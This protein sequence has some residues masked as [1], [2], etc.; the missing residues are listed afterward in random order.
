M[1]ALIASI[2][3]FLAFIYRACSPHVN[4]K[5]E[6]WWRFSFCKRFWTNPL[7]FPCLPPAGPQSTD[8]L[9]ICSFCTNCFAAFFMAR[10]LEVYSLSAS[11]GQSSCQLS[12]TR[13]IFYRKTLPTIFAGTVYGSWI[14]VLVSH[15]SKTSICTGAM[16][17]ECRSA[18]RLFCP[19][20]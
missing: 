18:N 11:H 19:L 6:L 8:T 9:D 3:H 13:K 7:F 4:V 12:K 1:E 2:S 5:R 17:I 20:R 10:K 14:Q 16:H 15:I